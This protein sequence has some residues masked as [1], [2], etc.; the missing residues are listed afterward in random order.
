[1]NV[2]SEN[3]YIVLAYNIVF[4]DV[5]CYTDLLHTFCYLDIY[6]TGDFFLFN[7][8]ISENMMLT[9]KFQ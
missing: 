3:N 1:M 8:I 2:R 5:F 9:P 4:I 6:K 7:D